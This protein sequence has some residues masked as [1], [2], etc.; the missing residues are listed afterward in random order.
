MKKLRDDGGGIV[1]GRHLKH[2]IANQYQNLFLSQA[3]DHESDVIQCV[4]RCVS[5]E[6]N[7]ALL[8]PFTSDEVWAALESIGDLKAPGADGMPSIFYKQFW[9]LLGERVKKEVLEVLNGGDMPQGWNDTIIVLIPKVKQPEKLK[10]LRPI[11]LCNVLYKLVSKVLAN[12]LK[13]ILPDIISP[14][15]SAF[16][17]GRMITDNVLLAYELTHHINNRRRGAGGLAAIKLDMS[18]AYDRIEWPFLKKMMQKLG[19]QEKWIDLIM[20]CVTT[21]SYRIKVNGEYTNRFFPQR[22][23]RQGDPLSPYLFILCAEGLSALLQQAESDGK[24]EGIKIRREASRV[25]HLFFC[26]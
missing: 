25:N 6:M 13:K 2:F 18:K 14:S 20:K 4:Q 17:P 1:E 5:P 16:V 19:F 12:R 23:L 3:G 9:Q 10:D 15:Q 22:G 7:E 21:V 11:S 26:R 24:I 8:A